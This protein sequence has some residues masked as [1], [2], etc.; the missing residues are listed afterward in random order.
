MLLITALSFSNCV[1]V[2]LSSTS[3]SISFA[4]NH[5]RGKSGHLVT[6]NSISTLRSISLPSL[7]K[8]F[9]GTGDEGDQLFLKAYET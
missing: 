4:L 5:S 1:Y 9:T 8:S 6:D 2:H 3:S 7:L